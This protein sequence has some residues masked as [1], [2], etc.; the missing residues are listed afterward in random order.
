[1]KPIKK[2]KSVGKII[3]IIILVILVAI[4]AAACAG[5]TWYRANLR[6]AN[7]DDSTLV[8]FAVAEGATTTNIAQNLEDKGL[9][10]SAL[11]FRLYMRLEAQDKNLKSGSYQFSSNMTV[12]E[13]VEKL[14]EGAKR[15]TFHI[16]FLPGGT[17]AAARERLQNAGYQDNE[18]TAAFTKNYDHPLLAGK[19]AENSLEGYIYGDT[20]EFYV[21]ASVSDILTATFD[22]MYKDIQ[23][24]GL[25]AKFQANGL[26]LYQAI[27]LASIVQ[28]EAGSLSDDMPKVA[29]IFYNRL[30]SNTPLGSDIIIGYYADRQNPNRSKTDMSYLNTTPCPWNSRKCVGLPP[31]PVNNPGIKA[32]NAVAN[33]DKD[34]VGYWYFLT[35]DD[36]KMYYARTEAEHNSNKQYC[37]KL[38]GI[39]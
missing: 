22:K 38:C 28:G 26:N 1:M 33:P 7:P 17:L 6:A 4:I 39:L 37:P 24:N 20:Y 2:R 21:G 30:N 27:T 10:R 32:L 11:A 34:Y 5:V 36:G 23:D 3:A 13:I 19:P 16:T 18:I 29:Q 14:H 8:D 9:I 31:N 25:I 35:G 15:Q 12:A